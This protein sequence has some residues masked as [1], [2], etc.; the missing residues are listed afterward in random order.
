MVYRI[1]GVIMKI[2]TPEQKAEALKR[3]KEIERYANVEIEQI[4]DN[5]KEDVI[6][7]KKSL[8]K[9]KDAAKELSERQFMQLVEYSTSWTVEEKL[10][11]YHNYCKRD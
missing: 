5:L 9:L 1:G 8:E 10:E 7:Y 6:F 3:K 2:K 4:P 11:F